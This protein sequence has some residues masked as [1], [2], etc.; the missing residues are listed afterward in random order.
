MPFPVQYRITVR[1]NYWNLIIPTYTGAKKMD[2]RLCDSL[3]LCGVRTVRSTGGCNSYITNIKIESFVNHGRNI[4][5]I[6]KETRK[7]T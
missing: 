6:M 4:Y 1:D 2:G 3:I 5:D 7:V